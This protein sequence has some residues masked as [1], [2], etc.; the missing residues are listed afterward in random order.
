MNR[1]FAFL[2]LCAASCCLHAQVVDTT[3]CNVLK[4]PKSFDGKTVRIKGTIVADFDQ[5]AI[6]DAGCGH[7]INSIW[8]DYP[9]G[10]KVKSGPAAVLVLQ[11]AHNFSGPYTAAQ[12]P[13]VQLDKSKD[14]KQF[15][16]LLAAPHKSSGMC[17]ACSKNEVS[18]TLVGRLDGVAE[19]GVRREGGKIVS[20][21]GF[22]NL[23]MYPARLVIQS[24]SDVTAK[25]A[26]FSKTDAVTKSDSYTDNEGSDGPATLRKAAAAFGATTQPGMQLEK[27]ADAFPKAKENN[28]VIIANGATNEASSK[29]EAQATTDSPDGVIYNCI[30]NQSRLQ[31]DQMVRAIAHFGQHIVDVRTPQS[32][33]GP[34]EYEYQAWG[35]TLMSGV[36]F[37]QKTLTLSGGN[38]VWNA[39]WAPADRDHLAD[40]GL[41][42]FL[43]GQES[44][45]R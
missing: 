19:A 43:T 17:L 34:Y 44:F 39:G 2:A 14:L 23:N 12:R 20:I 15:D 27:A 37:G 25:E 3:V 9:E 29:L 4:N 18:A 28:G 7:N 31:G 21:A 42:T 41:R 8:L 32:G 5:F 13:A 10:S 16:S 24:V 26:D 40:D 35:T 6:K 38:L 36:A 11:P 30:F 22:G 1:F 33:T 45:S